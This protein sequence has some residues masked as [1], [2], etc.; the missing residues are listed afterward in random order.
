MR[1]NA[2][3][4]FTNLVE[5]LICDRTIVKSQLGEDVYFFDVDMQSHCDGWKQHKRIQFRVDSVDVL[6]RQ[7]DVIDV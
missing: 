3:T 5:L 7:F 6:K 1:R 2:E 4:G